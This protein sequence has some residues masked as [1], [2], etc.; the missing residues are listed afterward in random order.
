MPYCAA[1]R[2][3]CLPVKDQSSFSGYLYARYGVDDA[4]YDR[5]Y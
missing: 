3:H 1:R 4:K 5:T 2:R